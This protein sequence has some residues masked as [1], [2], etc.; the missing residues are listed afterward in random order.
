ME[1]E[2]GHWDLGKKARALC[3]I[4][5]QKAGEVT[6]GRNVFGGKKGRVAGQQEE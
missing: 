5:G 3:A 1:K 4:I 2:S 6:A